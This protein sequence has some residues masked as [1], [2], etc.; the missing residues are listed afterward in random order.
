[1]DL[2][3]AGGDCTKFE[4]TR[5]APQSFPVLIVLA[6]KVLCAGDDDEGNSASMPSSDLTV[7]V[8]ELYWLLPDEDDPLNLDRRL[9]NGPP[10]DPDDFW[11][12]K[13]P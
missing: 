9:A 7:A 3:I 5:E 12:P 4:L 8:A 6:S 11:N 13:Y 10:E 1:M 2:N